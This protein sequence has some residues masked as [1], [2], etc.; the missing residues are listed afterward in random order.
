MFHHPPPYQRLLNPATFGSYIF[1]RFQTEPLSK[2][3]DFA[4]LKVM[5]QETIRNNNF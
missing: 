2:L 3:G 4:D 5:L 1:V